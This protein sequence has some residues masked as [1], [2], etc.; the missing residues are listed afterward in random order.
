MTR[1]AS[2]RTN[3]VHSY[4]VR[5]ARRF[6]SKAYAATY[7]KL[8]RQQIVRVFTWRGD[9]IGGITAHAVDRDAAPIGRSA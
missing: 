5:A 8:T 7:D 1:S 9:A 6:S 2:R 3:I 4:S